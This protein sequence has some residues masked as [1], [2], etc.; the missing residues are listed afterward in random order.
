MTTRDRSAP[1]ASKTSSWSSPT[2]DWTAWVVIA[3]PV[4]RAARAAARW[5]RSSWAD[6]HGLSV[7]DLADDPGPDPGLPH[8][9]GRVADD[10]VGQRVDRAAVDQRLG[11]VVG[12]A[13]PAAS[14]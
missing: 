4:R 1:S 9:L 10:L 8:A 5:T 13:I 12:A 7:A 11:R 2:V 3:R 14:P 6:S